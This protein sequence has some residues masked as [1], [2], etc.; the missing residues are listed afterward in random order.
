MQRTEKSR[1]Q[2]ST[3]C[4]G[5]AGAGALA[6]N[7]AARLFPSIGEWYAE[8]IYP[9][10]VNTLGR[11]CGWFPFSV[12]EAGIYVG[13]LLVLWLLTQLLRGKGRPE[14]LPGLLFRLAVA[15]W[16]L[17][18][19]NAGINYQRRTFSELAGY[20]IQE[21]TVEELTA[22]CED[23][24]TEINGAAEELEKE[25]VRTERK[26]TETAVRAMQRAGESYPA[27]AGYYPR[28]KR[29]RSWW[30]LSW[31]QLQGEYSPFTV[32]ANYNGHMP[33][34]D[35][36]S[37]VCHELSHLKGFMRE[38]EANFIAYLACRQSDSAA[39]RYSGALLAYIYSGNALYKADPEAYL[40][41]RAG[42]CAR[43]GTD[44]EEHNGYWRSFDGAV[45]KAS[46]R[47]NDAYLKA[48]A[49]KDGTASYGRMVDL[50]LAWKRQ[51]GGQ[52][53]GR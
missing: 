24:I 11:L 28:A 5:A 27:L 26:M 36:P 41:L 9:L 2:R 32:E 1:V 29:V 35:I 25:P 37:T 51:G 43:A 23:L 22:L 39:F 34:M 19:L 40:S 49:Q 7:L 42:L 47:M 20:E 50:L 10:W 6:L 13:L 3:L 21:S 8:Q 44:L 46:D 45:A 16:V 18:V 31:Q 14:Q 38:D 48:N 12:T 15:L 53:E 30:Y 4:W 52:D 33:E 17:F